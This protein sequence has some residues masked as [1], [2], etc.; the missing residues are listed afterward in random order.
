[1]IVAEMSPDLSTVMFST[2]LN[3]TDVSYGGSGFSG[4]AIDSSDK[5]ITTGSTNSRDFPTT[6][7]SFEPQLPPPAS[8]YSVPLRSFI[9]KID[10][11]TPAPSVCFDTLSVNF[12]KVNANASLTQTIHVT[13][14]GNAPLSI[15]AINSSD[16]TVAASQSCRT[17]AAG[18]V[19][20]ITL[21]FTPVSNVFTSGTITLSD[22]AVTIPQTVTFTGQGIA[23]RI[24]SGSNPL[25]FGHILIGTQGP[26]VPLMIKNTGQAQLSIGKVLLTGTSFSLVSQ[27]CTQPLSTNWTCA[28]QLSFSPASAGALSGSVVISSNDPVNPQLTVALTGVGDGAYGVPAIST[29]GASTVLIG[30]SNTTITVAGSNFYPQSVVQ[31]NGT[32]L[33]MTFLDNND[34]KAT[35][36]VSLITALGELPLTVQNPAPGGGISNALTVTPYQTLPIA[37]TSLV[38]VPATGLL[39]AAISASSLTNPNAV[40]PIDPK[41]GSTGTPIAV[42][43]NPGLLAASSDGAYLYVAGD[44][45]VLRINLKTNVV[46]RSFPYTPNLYCPSCT[47]LDATDLTTIPGSPQEVLLSQGSWLTLYNDAGSVNYVPNDGICCTADPNFGSIALAGNPLTI[48]GVPFTYPG[49]YFQVANLTSSG[50]QYTRPTVQPGGNYTTGNQVISDGTLLYTSAGQI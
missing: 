29:I 14:C 36:P 2:F 45:T 1:M 15:S 31:L 30:S 19:C 35:I 11:S 26:T 43:N 9:A 3:S 39:Y 34:L 8:P 7:G 5:L 20:P 27:N 21:T 32:A 6:A 33:S 46:E 28:I 12:G 16:P 48:Y 4:L 41:M 49:V 10:L 22:N 47:N 42:G 18:S 24:V 17:I 38:S 13:N 50:L 23:P 40:I 44:Q 25:S 37:P